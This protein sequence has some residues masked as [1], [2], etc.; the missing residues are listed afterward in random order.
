[1]DP[2]DAPLGRQ[3]SPARLG[4]ATRRSDAYRRGTFTRWRGAARR[5]SL[6]ASRLFSLS[7][8]AHHACNIACLR[9]TWLTAFLILLVAD[10]L[11]L[12]DWILLRPLTRATGLCSLLGPDAINLL[13]IRLC[14]LQRLCLALQETCSAARASLFA[15][16]RADLPSDRAL[17]E[18]GAAW[19]GRVR[20]RCLPCCLGS[21]RGRREPEWQCDSEP[22]A[23]GNVGCLIPGRLTSDSWYAPAP[24]FTAPSPPS[25]SIF[26]PISA[27]SPDRRR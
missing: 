23:P 14:C 18:P 15:I 19:L 10:L 16:I 3:V 26:H 17:R 11:A 8:T 27:A 4:P 24:H 12:L 20:H 6:A 2:F 21:R 25:A 22:Q 7:F 9:A 13:A 1:M 5:T